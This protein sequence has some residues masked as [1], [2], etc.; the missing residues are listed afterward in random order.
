MP[1]WPGRSYG[2]NCRSAGPFQVLSVDE[3]DAVGVRARARAGVQ[4]G[5]ARG[6]RVLIVSRNCSMRV[7]T[8]RMP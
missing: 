3:P 5:K 7:A 6:K 4:C 1:E 2:L 8:W